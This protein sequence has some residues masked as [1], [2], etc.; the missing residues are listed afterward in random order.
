MQ[1][2]KFINIFYICIG[3]YKNFN[4]KKSKSYSADCSKEFKQ[5]IREHDQS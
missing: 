2:Q 5:L 3:I 4:L 1:K